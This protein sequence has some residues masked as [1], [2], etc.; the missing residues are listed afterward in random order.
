MDGHIRVACETGEPTPPT[1]M[2]ELHALWDG[3]LHLYPA[4]TV[5]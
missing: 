5:S 2:G 1:T 4:L 3:T